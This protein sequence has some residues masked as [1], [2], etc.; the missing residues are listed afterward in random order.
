M[1]EENKQQLGEAKR[2]LLMKGKLTKKFFI[3][4]DEG[5]F[6]MSNIFDEN[7]KPVYAEYI[8]PLSE[9]EAQW[10][11]IIEVS[12]DQREMLGF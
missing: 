2:L 7:R 4:L 11:H 9:R 8:S 12:A 6:I 1:I 10:K 3:Q 5:T